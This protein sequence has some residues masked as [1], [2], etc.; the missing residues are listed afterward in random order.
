MF[1]NVMNNKQIRDA[2]AQGNLIITPFS[3]DRL[4]TIHYPLTPDKILKRGADTPDGDFE[5]DVKRDFDINSRA[6]TIQPA[7]YV[8][9]EISEHIKLGHNIVGHFITTSNMINKG[10]SLSAGRIEAPFG[11]FEGKRQMVRFGLT[12][13]SDRPVDISS[14]DRIA[15]VY[16]LDI[17]GLDNLGLE[18]TAEER[19]EYSAW[20]RRKRKASDD[21]VF[22]GDGSG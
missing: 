8:V 10:L 17:R 15:Y 20:I 6:Y 12:N 13:M 21:G 16:F 3:E 19:R 7:E 2:R 11:D 4:K 5:F 14:D 9:V 1:G 22:Y 18:M